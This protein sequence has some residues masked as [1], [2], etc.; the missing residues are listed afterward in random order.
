[1]RPRPL[2]LD[3][4]VTDL[5]PGGAGVAHAE[6]QGERRAVFVRHAAPGDR[7]RADVD[8]STRPARARLLAV[9]SGGPDR[10]PS[11]CRWSEKCGG[12]DWMHLSLEGQA[13]GHV[14]HIRAALPAPWRDIPIDSHRA[15][16][17]LEHRVRARV[18]VRCGRSGR[19]VVGMHGAGT[20]DPVEV[21]TC[22]VLDPALEIVRGQLAALLEGAHGRGDV[23]M[24]LGA[25]RRPVLEIRWDGEVA[26]QVFGRLEDAVASRVIAGANVIAGAVR[27]PAVIGDPTPW[28][29]G[30]DGRPLRLSPGGF[31]QA[32][33]PMNATLANHVAELVRRWHVGKAVELY[34]GAGN[35]SV[36]LAREVGELVCVESDRGACVAAQANLGDRGLD[37]TTRV[38]LAD[39]DTYA[40]GPATRM[41]VLDPP[42]T[43]ARAV[44]ER[45]ANART[46]Y[47]VYVSCDPPTLGRDLA[48]LR[49]T[50]VPVCIAAFEM[51]PNT[52]HV[53]VVV[54][55]ERAAPTIFGG[56]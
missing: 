29:T 11:P 56:R 27:R 50:H 9:L 31:G 14:E 38:V 1:M 20:H 37:A 42:R 22:A 51:F 54:A 7:V 21:D 36:V 2:R 19:A 25:G 33:E 53:E 17:A 48:L 13:R 43:G 41:V 23:Q 40:F 5:A 49:D 39:A 52:S 3:L 47:V 35:L 4:D 45:L 18:H 24:A 44:A 34:A 32:T 46:P 55:L 6:I 16:A 10:V 28:M 26:R 8:T 12:C 30:G 15:P